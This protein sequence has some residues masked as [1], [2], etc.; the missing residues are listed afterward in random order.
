VVESWSRDKLRT[1][2][3]LLIA[4]AAV[5]LAVSSVINVYVAV[6]SGPPACKAKVGDDATSVRVYA[7][8]DAGTIGAYA[9]VD[10]DTKFTP[11]PTPVGDWQPTF[12]EYLSDDGFAGRGYVEV[13][14][15]C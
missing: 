14:L 9:L 10:K 2:A 5:I 7:D 3:L 6:D 8:A 12:V 11:I 1:R 13:D 15:D 4:A